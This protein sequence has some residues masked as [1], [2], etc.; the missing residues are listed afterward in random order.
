M[1]G[2]LFGSPKMYRNENITEKML[3]YLQPLTAVSQYLPQISPNS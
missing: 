1:L 2:A 3:G